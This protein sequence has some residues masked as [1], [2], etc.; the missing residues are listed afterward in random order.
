MFR[1]IHFKRL[2]ERSSATGDDDDVS[3]LKSVVVVHELEI[4]RGIIDKAAT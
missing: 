1:D 4:P 2:T 3:V